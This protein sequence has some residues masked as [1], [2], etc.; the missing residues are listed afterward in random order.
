MQWL[1]LKDS[2]VAENASSK[3][4]MQVAE[5]WT[6]I[7][8]DNHVAHVEIVK[9]LVSIVDCQNS[10]TDDTRANKDPMEYDYN[11]TDQ[12]DGVGMDDSNALMLILNINELFDY[13]KEKL[14]LE[15]M[16]ELSRK[17]EH[18]EIKCNQLLLLRRTYQS[19]LKSYFAIKK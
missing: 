10:N 5:V 7:E 14:W 18:L 11:D 6:N 8:N 16:G 9:A 12:N 13:L 3:E 15:G 1:R 19:S 2:F 4:L 17:I